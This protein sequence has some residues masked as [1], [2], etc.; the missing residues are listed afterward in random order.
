[1][2]GWDGNWCCECVVP[3]YG[4]LLSFRVFIFPTFY[5]SCCVFF[6]FRSFPVVSSL[7]R[8][9]SAF[10][11]STSIV[12][13]LRLLLDEKHSLVTFR[14]WEPA[15]VF[16]FLS[17]MCRGGPYSLLS[18]YCS[19]TGASSYLYLSISFMHFFRTAGF[20]SPTMRYA[21]KHS[22]TL[23]LAPAARSVP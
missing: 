23:T 8:R 22:A 6:S 2:Q 19:S 5:F 11:A 20:P 17:M 1:M 21:A 13:C 9:I 15:V 16:L 10:R 7:L 18:C 14:L 3:V 4:V 12:R